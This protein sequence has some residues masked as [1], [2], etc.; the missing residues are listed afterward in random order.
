MKKLLLS[1][2]LAVS[3][4]AQWVPLNPVTADE[5]RPN[6]VTLTMQK[7]ATR[8]DICSDSIVH[9]IYSPSGTFPE[10][11]GYV[12]NKKSWPAS[13]FTR[14]VKPGGAEMTL[15]TP[16]LDISVT[17]ADGLISFS[18]ASGG[19]LVTEG[20][21]TMTPARVNGECTYHAEDN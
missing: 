16:R 2:L 20:P 14:R 21:K 10:D 17:K 4:S 19:K 1:L 9:V 15:V 3:L 11:P 18:E 8:I 7:G 5:M 6:G 12:V 13:P